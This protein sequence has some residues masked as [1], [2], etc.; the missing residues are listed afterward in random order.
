MPDENGYKVNQTC[1]NRIFGF[2]DALKDKPKGW[3]KEG[4][5]IVEPPAALANLSYVD[6]RREPYKITASPGG[7]PI[8]AQPPRLKKKEK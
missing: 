7:D 5:S 3:A 6:V 8:Q 1:D 4:Y 2:L